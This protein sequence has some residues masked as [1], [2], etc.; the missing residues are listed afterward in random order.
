MLTVRETVE[1]LPPATYKLVYD[2]MTYPFA[3]GSKFHMAAY[4]D[5]NVEKVESGGEGVFEL[6]IACKPLKNGVPV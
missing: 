4:G 1:F 2:G 3:A 5:F 6:F